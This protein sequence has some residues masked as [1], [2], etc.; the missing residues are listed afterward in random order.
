ML[1]LDDVMSELDAERREQL[2][3]FLKLKKIQTIITAT[4]R[5]YFPEQDFGRIF[6]VKAGKIF[7]KG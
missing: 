2:L 3:T 6:Y 1:L 7:L 5:K 4:E